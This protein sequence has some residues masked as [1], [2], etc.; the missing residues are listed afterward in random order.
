M[1]MRIK[2]KQDINDKHEIIIGDTKYS[3][4]API[5]I[6]ELYGTIIDVTISKYPQY[7]FFDGIWNWHKDWLEEVE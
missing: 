4:T 3:I 1:Q 5:L 7:T 2:N 6:D